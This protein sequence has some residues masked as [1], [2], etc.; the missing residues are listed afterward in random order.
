M[1]ITC[2]GVVQI[3]KKIYSIDR[4]YVD[5]RWKK[6]INISDKKRTIFPYIWI[7]FKYLLLEKIFLQFDKTRFNVKDIM[8][9]VSKFFE[10]PLHNKYPTKWIIQ[11]ISPT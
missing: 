1:K 11:A 6:S 4:R 2:L 7:H 5:L 9:H 10:T 8:L 3:F